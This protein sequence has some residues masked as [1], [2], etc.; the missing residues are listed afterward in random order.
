MVLSLA[1]RPDLLKAEGKNLR[2]VYTPL[3]GSGNVPVRRVLAEAGIEN[4]T[5][6]PEQEHP[7]PDFSTVSAP[8]PENPDAFSLAIPLAKKVGASVIFGTD[9]DC[10]RL[11][12]CVLDGE[13][14]FR[15][16]TGNQ[17]GVLL[18]HHILSS[19]KAAGTLPTNGACIKSIVTTELARTICEDY[20]VEQ[21][22]VLTGFKF[23]GEKMQQFEDTGSHTFLFGFEE[24]FGYLSSTRVRDKDGV[25]ASLL[26]AEAACACMAEGITLYDRLQQI[27]ARYGYYSEKVVS[28][29]LPGK[30]GL[31]DMRNLM[32]RLRGN[33]PS[34]AGSLNVLAVRD[35]KAGTRTAAGKTEALDCPPSDVLYYELEGGNW[36]CMRPS[37]TEPK[38]KLYVNARSKASMAEADALC[39]EL[40]QAGEAWLE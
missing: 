40:Q 7:D 33:P 4:V 15:T 24:S 16:L 3:H 20:G 1:V 17:I 11:G 21:F 38:I 39:A 32:A 31:T 34:K 18:L 13:G 19:R 29:T 22:D 6:V 10:D 28:K 25:N 30:D 8:N 26:I 36:L 5:V 2:I 12:V 37:G 35:Y 23:I 27:F 14:T 9:P